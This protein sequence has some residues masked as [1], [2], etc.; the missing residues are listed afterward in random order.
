MNEINLEF[1]ESIPK[2]HKQM[3]SVRKELAFEVEK[4]HMTSVEKLYGNRVLNSCERIQQFNKELTFLIVELTILKNK[5]KI[6]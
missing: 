3:E 5:P 4:L 2:I 1:Q 6:N